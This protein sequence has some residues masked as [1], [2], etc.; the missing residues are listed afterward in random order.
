MRTAF[1]ILHYLT[2]S[3]TIECVDS[4]INNIKFTEYEIVIVDNYSNNGSIEYLKDKLMYRENIHFIELKANLGFAKGNNAGYLYAKN[5]LKVDFIILLNNDTIIEQEDFLSLIYKKFEEEKFDILGPDIISSKNMQ[6]QNPI[7]LHGM[8]MYELDKMIFETKK[9]IVLNNIYY[10]DI[11][12]FL[13]KI[14]NKFGMTNTVKNMEHLP[15]VELENVPLHGSCLIFSSGFIK[16]YNGLYSGTFMFAEEDLLYYIAQKENL[17]VIFWPKVKI[18][19]K[20]DSSTDAYLNNNKAKR[21]F[22]FKNSLV[23]LKIMKEIYLNDDI[24]KR[25]MYSV[26]GMENIDITKG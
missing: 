1:V 5:T 19:H 15:Q 2:Y 22:Q 18:M 23:S 24:Y 3:D 26:N 12:M 17:K 25:D 21:S 7:A 20:E 4:I 10:Y 8:S 11:R 6:H 14:L 9:K 13:K 16:K